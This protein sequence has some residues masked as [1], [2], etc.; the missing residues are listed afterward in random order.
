MGCG[1]VHGVGVAFLI[2]GT[3]QIGRAAAHALL[4]EGWEVVVASRSGSLPDG[5]AE[6]G[7]HAVRVDRADD[8]RLRAALGDGADVVVDMV[9]FTREHA[10]QLIAL[11]GIVGS[12]VVISSASVYADDEGRT[13]DEATTLDTSPCLPV[14][15]PE[16]QR[17][18]A[19]GDATYSTRKAAMEETLLGG[20]LPATV[21]RPCAIHGP[22]SAA[23]RELFFVRRVLDG[24]RFA[25][26]VQNG[27]SRFHTTSVDNLAELIRLAAE[28]PGTRVLNCG[29]PEPPTTREIGAAIVRAMEAELELRG[30][31]ESG[32]DRPEL[33]NPWAVAR[34][35]VL[36]MSTAAR[37]LGYRPATTYADAV[38]ETCA[39]LVRELEQRDFSDTYL[40]N[41]FN[42]ADED[43]E[44]RQAS[45]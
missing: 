32:Y 25:V 15:I 12:V 21:L 4:R 6:R 13:L 37:D 11:D 22:G 5:L 3:G 9:A 14:P 35:F 34:P 27:E 16:T 45:A 23:P 2:G 33:S 8:A 44:R 42:Y 36:D 19:A 18:A 17:T 7:A 10:D 38:R 31:A 20:P 41:Y 1:N 43:A 39:W 24:R 40:A 30:I 26:L 29:D 28:R